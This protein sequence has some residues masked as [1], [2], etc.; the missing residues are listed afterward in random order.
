MST[1]LKDTQ[2][3]LELQ[4]E[5]K[6]DEPRKML[7]SLPFNRI[8]TIGYTK[9]SAEEFFR[10]LHEAGI[11]FLI[12]IRANT[13]YGIS[14][15]TFRRDFE[16]FCNLHRIELIILEILAPSQKIR[17]AFKNSGD[18]NAYVRSFIELMNQRKV[19]ADP[20]VRKALYSSD[21]E[22]AI[23]FLCAE[24]T[25]YKCHRRL[26]VEHLLKFLPN[27]EDIEVRHL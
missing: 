15:Y 13:S 19:F 14:G 16:Y 4:P 24:P 10:L 22:G 27:A 7:P 21:N 11:I 1:D 3:T 23:C 26:V 18:W 5:Q 9:K 8:C 17:D 6:G 12:D 25:A 20:K 2:G